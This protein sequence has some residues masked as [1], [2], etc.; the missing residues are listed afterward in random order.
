ML[1][2]QFNDTVNC[3]VHC[4]T[5]SQWIVYVCSGRLIAWNV[6]IHYERIVLIARQKIVIVKMTHVPATIA[7]VS[8]LFIYT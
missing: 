6:Q 7:R 3:A 2:T 5:Y 1:L 8:Y 4:G